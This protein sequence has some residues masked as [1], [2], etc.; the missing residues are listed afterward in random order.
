MNFKKGWFHTEIT[1][2]AKK[3][4]EEA[5]TKNA[6]TNGDFTKK[7]ESEFRNIL[8]SPTVLYSNS[9]TSSI[10][11]ALLALGIGR[12]NKIATSGIGWI[13]TIQAAKLTG[14]DVMV[15]DV[16]KNLPKLDINQLIKAKGQFDT[17]IPVNY[18]GRQIDIDSLKLNFPDCY[19]VEDS[20]KS[21]LSKDFLNQKYSGTNGNFGCFSLGMI[22]MVPG[23][24]GGLTVSNEIF[25]Y[26]KL[27][28]L[29]WHGTSYK[30]N[31]ER[32]DY[33]SYNFKTSNI[34]AA[35]ALGMLDDYLNRIEK[36][37][38]IYLIYKDG[39]DGLKNNRLLEVNIS[40]GEIPLLIDIVSENRA[41]IISKLNSQDIPT[42][43]YHNSLDKANY[44][45]KSE[46]LIYSDYFGSSVFHPPC[47]PD[48][49][50]SQIEKAIK[51]IK[52]F[53]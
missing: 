32:Y 3:L 1:P 16:E 46:D 8:K 28:C 7:L 29:K 37:Q 15:F 47:G 43:N 40:K 9:G 25:D 18:N 12:Q 45:Q 30:D 33:C 50:F 42:C 22:S 23:I 11:L 39:L 31:N 27:A 24:Y 13:A 4:A 10:S 36:L 49:D 26:E 41:E 2:L 5:I 34:N 21:L 35:I 52:E 6:F 20:C 38:E 19:I 53:G 14:A 51:L 17:I 48:Q 44:V